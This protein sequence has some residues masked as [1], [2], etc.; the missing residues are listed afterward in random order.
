PADQLFRALAAR[1]P[2]RTAAAAPLRR[3]ETTSKPA[4]AIDRPQDRGD[5]SGLELAAVRQ[6]H[7]LGGRRFAALDEVRQVRQRIDDARNRRQRF[8]DASARP[9]EALAEVDLL[10][11]LQE[12]TPSELLQV[13]ADRIDFGPAGARLERLGR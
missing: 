9:V 10:L 1:T 6:Q 11:R 12:R 8:D 2:A 5:L 3:G 13:S 4:C 7:E